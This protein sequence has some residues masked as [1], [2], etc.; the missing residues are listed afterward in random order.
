MCSLC[1]GEVLVV[2]DELV[3]TVDVSL[4]LLRRALHRVRCLPGLGRT[5]F[6]RELHLSFVTVVA[7][8]TLEGN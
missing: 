5:D 7:C 3:N 6:R 8:C 4:T 1:C 2:V